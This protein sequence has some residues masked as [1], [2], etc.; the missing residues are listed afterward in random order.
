MALKCGGDGCRIAVG[1]F[2][3]W[4]VAE[5]FRLYAGYHGNLLERPWSLTIFL[6]LSLCP[7]GAILA[8][9]IFGQVF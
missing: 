3:I 8:F 2:S 6:V 9:L 5:P 1:A 4:A 7:Q